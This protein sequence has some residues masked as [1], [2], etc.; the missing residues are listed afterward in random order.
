[1]RK[2]MLLCFCFILVSCARNTGVIENELLEESFNS[3]NNIVFSSD[4]EVLFKQYGRKEMIVLDYEE[5]RQLK[6]LSDNLIVTKSDKGSVNHD[7]V[8]IEVKINGKETYYLRGNTVYHE[9]NEQFD[10]EQTIEVVSGDELYTYALEMIGIEILEKDIELLE[11]DR[12]HDGY[13]DSKNPNKAEMYQKLTNRFFELEEYLLDGYE[14]LVNDSKLFV[15]V[16]DSYVLSSWNEI[17]EYPFNTLT[18]YAYSNNDM[19]KVIVNCSYENE[20]TS[21]EYQALINENAF[22]EYEDVSSGNVELLEAYERVIIGLANGFL[23]EEYVALG[24][25]SDGYIHV[26]MLFNEELKTYDDI[27]EYLN[28]F[29][30]SV[31]SKKL[32]DI[33]VN[34]EYLKFDDGIYLVDGITVSD[35]L[36]KAIKAY[37]VFETDEE[38]LIIVITN[39]EYGYCE[40]KEYSYIFEN[41][42]WLCN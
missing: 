4:D 27:Y 3:T 40:W 1:M 26:D 10:G 28:Q 9:V 24:E 29:F 35:E 8:S 13:L 14:E 30:S 12:Y 23:N 17:F 22:K 16:N 20:D 5:K 31:K 19:I 7:E 18:K 15:D 2:L 34:S 37:R 21:C 42:L 41:N 33:L 32:C 25:K 36:T 11:I 39:C 38:Q 6:E